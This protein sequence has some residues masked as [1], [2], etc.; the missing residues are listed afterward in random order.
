M[1]LRAPHKA[2]APDAWDL[3]GGHVEPGETPL[4]ALKRE[5]L[6][7]IGVVVTAASPLDA[8]P[9][10]HLE[11]PGRLHL[12]RVEGWRGDPVLANDE[13]VDLRWFSVR[14]LEAVTNLA[15]EAYREIFVRTLA[16]S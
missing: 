13:H 1:G 11:A 12:F 2:V 14:D 9:F 7:E 10:V 4:A 16:A 3:I 15:F 6:E 8:L 5:V